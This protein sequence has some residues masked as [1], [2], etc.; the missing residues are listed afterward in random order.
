[1]NDKIERKI[2][3]IVH[4]VMIVLFRFFFP[5]LRLCLFPLILVQQSCALSMI[6]RKKLNLGVKP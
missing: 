2:N 4:I 6:A 5:S 3:L 1:M